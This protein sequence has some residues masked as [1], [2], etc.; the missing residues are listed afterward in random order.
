M[1]FSIFTA[2]S[3]VEKSVKFFDKSPNKRDVPKII[4]LY[5]LLLQYL[6]QVNNFQNVT[7]DQKDL[8]EKFDKLHILH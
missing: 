1:T 6:I 8:F 7:F 5:L 3:C 2:V 4:N